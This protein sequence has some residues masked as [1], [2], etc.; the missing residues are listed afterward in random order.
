MTQED[1][2]AVVDDLSAEEREDL[3]AEW[4]QKLRAALED[5]GKA[6]SPAT[7]LRR[8]QRCMLNAVCI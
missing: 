7:R 1:Y 6:L 5:E 8:A 3:R 2:H 4:Q